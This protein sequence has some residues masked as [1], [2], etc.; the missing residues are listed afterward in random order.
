MKQE[1][2]NN[3]KPVIEEVSKDQIK[4]DPIILDK[5][6]LHQPPEATEAGQDQTKPSDKIPHKEEVPHK[7]PPK[8]DE[9]E[10]KKSQEGALKKDEAGPQNDEQHK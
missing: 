8:H 10:V 4:P 5:N 1:A 3:G 2:W 6:L 7:E 9:K